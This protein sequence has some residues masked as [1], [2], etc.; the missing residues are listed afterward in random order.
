MRVVFGAGRLDALPDEVD[1]LGLRNVLILCS[2][3]QQALGEQVAALL[4]GRVAGVFARARMH[5][6]VETAAAGEAETRRLNAD[7]CVS[8]GGGSA[9]GLGKVIALA[10]GVPTICVPTTYSGSE[11]TP[12]W[13]LTDSGGKTTGRN[14]VVLP[15]TVIYDPEMTLVLPADVSATSG[16]N[17]VAHA[18]EA[19]Y[20][21]D[22]SPMTALMAQESIRSLAAALPDV[23]ADPSGLAARTAALRGSWLAGACLGAT[24]MGLHHKVCHALGG[25][26]DLPHATTHAVV[27]PHVAAFNLPSAPDA[28]AAVASALNL[29]A[30]ASAPNRAAAAS[31]LRLAD[32]AGVPD[33]AAVAGVPDLAAVA[34]VPD[35]ANATNATYAT[36]AADAA[37]AANTLNLADVARGGR[38]GP[39]DPAQALAD[40]AREL[41]I[42]PSLADL[43]L[44][45]SDL[46]AAAD[47]I[48]AKPYANPRPVTREDLLALLGRALRGDA[49]AA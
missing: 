45:G 8:V 2:A 30:A 16:M 19:L 41:G 15:R 9:V 38:A 6:P 34:G 20:A 46:D 44:R 37:D 13:G 42:P 32:M 40:L 14:P 27:L 5:V 48:L 11:M 28:Y 31:A 35:L 22:G 43:G 26:F 39:A 10:T 24:T 12:V 23:V 1:R 36:N 21:P 4:P 18:V 47:A 17:A 29:A 25:L 7:G 33:L 3:R 49:P